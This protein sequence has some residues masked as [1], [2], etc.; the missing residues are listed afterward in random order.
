M[1]TI[2]IFN[3]CSNTFFPKH[4]E[5]PLSFFTH[6]EISLSGSDHTKSHSNP[7]KLKIAF[8]IYYITR[9]NFIFNIRG[10]YRRLPC[11]GISVGLIIP[12]I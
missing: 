5:I 6:S 10:K 8:L 7:I 2:S 1:Q 4:F 9:K 11:S 12:R 3:F